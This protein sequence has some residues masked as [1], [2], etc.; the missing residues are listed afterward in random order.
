MQEITLLKPSATELPGYAA[1]LERDWFADNV[2]KAEAAREHLER[3]ATDATAFL[4]SLD[5]QD[6]K[7]DPIKLPDRSLVARL[8]GFT[9]WIWDGE[10]CGSINFRWQRGTS[11]LPEH[12]LGHIGYSVVPWKRGAGYA[13][14][15]LALMLP[16]AKQ[17]GLSYVEL[18]TSPGND[19][20]QKVILACGGR[21]LERFVEPAAYGSGEGLRFRVDLADVGAGG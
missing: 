12:V 14:Q 21:L 17:R 16:Q 1:A 20:S 19:A 13:K 5:D 7:K 18:T 4:A 9:R 3:I 6:A 15:A 2:R 11:T 10:F 8:P